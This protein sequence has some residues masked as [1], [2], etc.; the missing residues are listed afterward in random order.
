MA[1]EFKQWVVEF[2]LV[3]LVA[4]ALILGRGH[5]TSQAAA[6]KPAASADPST[7]LFSTVN[8]QP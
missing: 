2:L 6:T 3:V 8:A 5:S 1:S 4:I 7:V